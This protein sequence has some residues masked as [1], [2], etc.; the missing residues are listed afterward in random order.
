MSTAIMKLSESG[1]FQKIHQK[2]FCKSGCPGDERRKSQPN[3]LHLSSFWALYSLCGIFALTAFFLF[4]IRAVHQYI[5]YKRRQADPSSP[6]FSISSSVLFSQAIHN[7]LDFIDEKEEAIK[8][9]F[10][11][12]DNPPTQV[13]Q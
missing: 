8:R 2:W 6:A 5:V 7:F 3:K 9:F 12:H 13:S 10:A 4:L 1:E 11:Q